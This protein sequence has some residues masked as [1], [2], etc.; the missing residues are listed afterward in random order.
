V[1]DAVS[2]GRALVA[3]RWGLWD[4]LWTVLGWAVIGLAVGVLFS[5]LDAPISVVIIVGTSAPWLA[6]A[7][8]P[9]W[10]TWR[11]GNGPRIDLG[12]RL[13]WGDAGWGA[14]GGALALLLAGIA[15]VVTQLVKPDMTSAAAEA[16]KQLEEQGGRLVMV[17]F[18]LMVMVG[19]PVV[20]ELFFRGLLFGAVR[21]R[22]AGAVLTVVITAIVF[23]GFHFEPV[24]FFV[25][26][27]SGLVLGWVRW[28]TGSTGASMVAHGLVNAP[29]AIALLV[30]LTGMSP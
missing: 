5:K 6:L 21:K 24:R 16:G 30:G 20:E 23:A 7:G 3:P 18:A 13:T 11:R 29:G 12:L 14:V 1:I 15:A 2:E 19:A 4:V 26:L 8:W 28:R 22:G 27:P 17:V 25:L 9:L 10:A